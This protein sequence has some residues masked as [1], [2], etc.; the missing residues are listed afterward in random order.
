ML[1]HHLEGHV[2]FHCMFTLQ[3][4]NANRLMAARER[5]I[6]AVCRPRRADERGALGAP[7][8]LRLRHRALL[9]Q[10]LAKPRH[11]LRVGL[12]LLVALQQPLQPAVAAFANT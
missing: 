4:E 10:L 2:L 5:A 6:A 3:I 12:V 11:L 8:L 7:F 9:P 1:S